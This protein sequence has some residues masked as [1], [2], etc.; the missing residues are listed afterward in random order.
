M[1]LL[2]FR[3]QQYSYRK[4]WKIQTYCNNCAKTWPEMALFIF[5]IYLLSLSVISFICCKYLN[6]TQ[7]GKENEYGIRRL[8]TSFS[9]SVFYIKKFQ[10]KSPHDIHIHN[11]MLHYCVLVVCEI[12]QPVSILE[13]FKK[14]LNIRQFYT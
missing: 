2:S 8:Y 1:P 13:L 7:F 11:I 14:Y 6:R 3:R 9:E 5:K 4:K 10:I 12:S